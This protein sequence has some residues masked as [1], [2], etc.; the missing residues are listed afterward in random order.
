[1]MPRLR[2]ETRSRDRI[3][4]GATTWLRSVAVLETRQRP[5]LARNAAAMH[6]TPSADAAALLT[7]SV[8]GDRKRDATI[9]AVNLGWQLCQS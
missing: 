3:R 1:M 9:T 6:V 4:H 2:S 8:T 7:A 5:R